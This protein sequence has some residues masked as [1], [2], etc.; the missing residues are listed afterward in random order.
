MTRVVAVVQAR[1]RSSRLPGKVLKMF[2]DKTF[3]EHCMDRCR[4]IDGVDEVVCATVDT[5]D[6]DV[7]VD[8]CRKRGYRWFRGSEMNAVNRFN[9]AAK[10]AKADAVVRVTSDNPLTDPGITGDVTAAFRAGG[11]DFVT[12]NMPRRWPLGLDAE[13]ISA[14]ALDEAD[15]EAV[16]DLEREH[17]TTFVR[18]R[19]ERYRLL[20]LPCPIEDRSHWRLTLD[21]ESDRAMFEELARR[22]GMPFDRARWRDVIAFIDANPDILEINAAA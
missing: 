8:L 12:T 5:P 6:C 7:V 2:G 21:T 20:N 17:V 3:L 16:D 22:I 14:E 1:M 4:E 18:T 13:I 11:Y 15:R 9:L 10:D 19:P